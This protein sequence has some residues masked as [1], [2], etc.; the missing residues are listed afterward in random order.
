[1]NVTDNIKKGK[2][3]GFT[4][5]GISNEAQLEQVL[6]IINEAKCTYEMKDNFTSY[7]VRGDV[8]QLEKFTILWNK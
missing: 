7:V 1:M 6:E 4:I 3:I 8:K 2:L 5:R